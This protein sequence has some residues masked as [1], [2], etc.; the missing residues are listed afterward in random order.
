MHARTMTH[1]HT[2]LIFSGD[3]LDHAR[4]M[5]TIDLGRRLCARMRTTQNTTTTLTTTVTTTIHILKSM[6][7]SR[8]FLVSPGELPRA[9]ASK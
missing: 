1:T 5:L 3:C 9:S 4:A 6:F 7:T 8:A 2:Q